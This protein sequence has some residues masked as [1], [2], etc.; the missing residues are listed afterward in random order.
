V[1]SLNLQ[2]G[3]CSVDVVDVWAYK[4]QPQGYDGVIV[5]ASVHI[6]LSEDSRNW[7]RQRRR[8]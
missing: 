8:R 2:A 7:V 5:A 6:G 3:L 1:F 4:P